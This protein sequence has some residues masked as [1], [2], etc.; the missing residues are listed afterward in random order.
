MRT[1]KSVVATREM[2]VKFLRYHCTQ[3][4]DTQL[5]EIRVTS[6]REDSNQLSHSYN[7]DE[8]TTWHSHF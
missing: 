1:R 4:S 2:K 5:V 7:R 6:S 3:V 8:S